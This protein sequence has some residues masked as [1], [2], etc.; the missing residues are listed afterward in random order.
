[1]AL[2]AVA[3]ADHD[4]VR[5][6]RHREA[7]GRQCLHPQGARVVTAV[8]LPHEERR[9]VHVVHHARVD[10][11]VR[12]ADERPVVGVWA[13]GLVGDTDRHA[14]PAVLLARAVVRE[15]AVTVAL[16]PRP[17]DLAAGAPRGCL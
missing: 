15:V 8:L 3:A 5:R 13:Y 9:A 2:P 10:R 4:L 16:E 6:A 14:W 7:V 1:P 12:L 17:P 11:G